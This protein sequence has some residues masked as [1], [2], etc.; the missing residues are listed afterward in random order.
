MPVSP[1]PGRAL[2]TVPALERMRNLSYLEGK[3]AIEA[4]PAA[5]RLLA[6]LQE[7]CPHL[8]ARELVML[9]RLNGEEAI[10]AAAHR[11]EY[12]RTHPAPRP[13]A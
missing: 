3:E 12:N 11:L 6:R 8:A 2:Q 1:L 5:P 10:L 4:D 9:F 7:E 13:P